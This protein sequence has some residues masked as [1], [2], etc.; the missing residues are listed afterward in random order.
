MFYLLYF[1]YKD[2]KILPLKKWRFK[3]KIPMEINPDE[4]VDCRVCEEHC[5]VGAIE[6]NE[7][8]K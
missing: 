5:P 7:K 6:N 1:S 4:C 2:I 8:I 3:L